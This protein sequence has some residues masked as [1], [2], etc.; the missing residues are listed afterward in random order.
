VLTICYTPGK[1]MR[2][3][4][5]PSKRFTGKERAKIALEV[6]AYGTSTVH[7]RNVIFNNECDD[8]QK[9]NSPF[10]KLN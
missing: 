3:D 4:V 10:F 7:H 2:H 6:M 5:V 1:D 9:S 8:P